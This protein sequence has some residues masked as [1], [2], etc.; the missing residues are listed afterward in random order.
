MKL[1]A[2][3]FQTQA[4]TD[5]LKRH[6]P[7][8]FFYSL[9]VSG[10]KCIRFTALCS[11]DC[12]KSGSFIPAEK[13]LAGLEGSRTH[14]LNPVDDVAGSAGLPVTRWFFTCSK[15]CPFASFSGSGH[16]LCKETPAPYWQEEVG[17][18]VLSNV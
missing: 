8:H 4:V 7:S 10:N 6:V 15:L 14:L 16:I 9:L 17:W 5:A 3:G 13:L 18:L 2:V 1:W 11:C 12:T